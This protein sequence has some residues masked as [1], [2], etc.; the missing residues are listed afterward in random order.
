MKIKFFILIF[1]VLQNITINCQDLGSHYYGKGGLGHLEFISDS[2]CAISF[3]SNSLKEPFIDTAYYHRNGDTIFISTQ[4]KDRYEIRT[5]DTQPKFNCNDYA[6]IQ[7]YTTMR[8][9]KYIIYAHYIIPYDTTTNELYLEKGNFHINVNWHPILYYKGYHRLCFYCCY[10]HLS[11]M[12][13]NIVKLMEFETDQS[14]FIN[15]FPLIIKRNRLVPISSKYV[16]NTKFYNDNGF[17]FSIMRSCKELKNYKTLFIGDIAFE[18]IPAS[19]CRPS[20]RILMTGDHGNFKIKKFKIKPKY[21]P[22]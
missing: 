13:Y 3:L 16:A 4:I 2:L 11:S 6:I 14:L 15:E 22:D 17:Y 18:G 12:H 9:R 8:N 1:I 21:N 10:S 19:V 7:P 5:Y 20:N